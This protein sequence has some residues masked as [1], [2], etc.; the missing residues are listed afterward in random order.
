MPK[1][2]TLSE[3]IRTASEPKKKEYVALSIRVTP[4]MHVRLGKLTRRL[5]ITQN[6]LFNKMLE[7]VCQE[8]GC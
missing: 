7:K 8:E 5:D 4:D 6:E 1:S 2:Q 3:Y